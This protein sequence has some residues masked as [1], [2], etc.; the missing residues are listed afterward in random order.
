[1]NNLII[2]AFLLLMMTAVIL[3]VLEIR[4]INKKLECLKYI[5]NYSMCEN[6]VKGV[7]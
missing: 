4:I 2:K 1:M 6:I 7:K 5:Q 3:I